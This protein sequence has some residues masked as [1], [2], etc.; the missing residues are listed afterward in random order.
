VASPDWYASAEKP[1]STCGHALNPHAHHPKCLIDGFTI[2]VG[3]GLDT[4][5]HLSGP[6]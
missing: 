1:P 5:R 6:S 3:H 4:S 2:A